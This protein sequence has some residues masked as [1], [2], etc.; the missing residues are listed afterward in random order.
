M[1]ARSLA[2]LA[3]AAGL[4]LAAPPAAA[5]AAPATSPFLGEWQLDLSRMPDTYGPPPR[6][7]VFSFSA[8]GPDLW[9][10]TVEITAPDGTVRRIAAQYRRDGRAVPSTGDQ[11][12]GDSGAFMSPAPNILVASL[13]RDR[14]AAG[15]RVYVISEDGREMT[16]SA[17]NVDQDGQPF[18]RNFHFTKIGGPRP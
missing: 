8:V 7:V 3:A 1:T 10:T 15:V 13:A 14:Q 4:A 2:T 17:A 11:A 6:R 5:A 16:E 9:R 18:V 12:D